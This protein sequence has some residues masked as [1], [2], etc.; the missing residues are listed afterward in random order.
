MQLLFL[1]DTTLL[2]LLLYRPLC[3]T[4]PSA[5]HF[6]CFACVSARLFPC[7]SS[8]CLQCC[9]LLCLP[10]IL[11]KNRPRSPPRPNNSRRPINWSIKWSI[12]CSSDSGSLSQPIREVTAD[13]GG[14]SHLELVKVRCNVGNC[15]EGACSY[16]Q[17]CRYF[18]WWEWFCHIWTNSSGDRSKM[19]LRRSR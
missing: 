12:K 9:L 17:D 6:A 11:S 7:L 16:W 13:S 3:L 14:R 19:T 5:C 15:R 1:E 4:L 10:L 2:F 8:V 18:Q